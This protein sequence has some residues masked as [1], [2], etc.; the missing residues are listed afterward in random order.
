ML[1]QARIGPRVPPAVIVA[2]LPAELTKLVS[3]LP[4]AG[5]DFLF[6]CTFF[7]SDLYNCRQSLRRTPSSTGIDVGKQN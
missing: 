1:A 3:K 2:H 5:L 7:H 4:Q 6:F